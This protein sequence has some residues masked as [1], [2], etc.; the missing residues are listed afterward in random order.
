MGF[1]AALLRV[2]FEI[3][4]TWKMLS[5]PKVYTKTEGTPLKN[6]DIAQ[7]KKKNTTKERKE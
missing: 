2:V 7:L 3:K 6:L 5:Q 1:A 4:I